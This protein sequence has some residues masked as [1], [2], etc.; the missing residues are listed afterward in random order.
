MLKSFRRLLAIQVGA[1]LT[2]AAVGFMSAHAADADVV[3]TVN[4]MDITEGD[5]AVAGEEYGAQFGNLPEPQR[6]AALLSGMIEIRLLAAQAEEKGLDESEKFKSRLD[7]MRKQALHAA[8]IEEVVNASVTEEDVRASYDKQVADTPPVNEVRARHILVKEKEEAEAIIKQLDEG[9][10]FEEIAKEKSTDGVASKGGDLGYFSSGQMVPEFEKAAFAMNPG[11]Y[12]K[13]PVETQF[14]FHVIK[15]EDKR[16][17]QPPAFDAVKD[18]VRSVLVRE[19]YVEQVSAL[20]DA[21]EVQVK[22]ASLKEFLDNVE[23]QREEAEAEAAAKSEDAKEE[24][25]KSE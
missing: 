18:R 24:D 11:E 13:E 15:V 10:N 17:K 6:R 8:F 21:A 9:G 14:G 22:D 16:A 3:A 23:K 7:F 2:L 19:K 20:R 4:G 12:S 25:A 5:L 1:G